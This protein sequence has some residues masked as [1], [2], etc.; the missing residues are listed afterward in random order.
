MRRTGFLSISL[1]FLMMG[2]HLRAGRANV[3]ADL[4]CDSVAAAMPFPAA[5]QITILCGDNL[6]EPDAPALSHCFARL[7]A[8]PVR[9]REAL[10]GASS[11]LAD[12]AGEVH[13]D[14]RPRQR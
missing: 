12:P 9:W 1:P 10:A 11:G 14:A 7:A 2:R 6:E 4:P 5:A 13:R 8:C 3:N